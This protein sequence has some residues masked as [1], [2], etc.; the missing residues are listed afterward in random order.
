MTSQ[1]AL[2]ALIIIVALFAM[3]EEHLLF[4]FILVLLAIEA[5]S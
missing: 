1:F 5:A 3:L 2:A 4:A